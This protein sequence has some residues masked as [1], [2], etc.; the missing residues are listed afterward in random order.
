MCLIYK[1]WEET[2]SIR[3]RLGR[4]EFSRSETCRSEEQ[5]DEVWVRQEG[6]LEEHLALCGDSTGHP[7]N[8][9]ERT[10]V[11]A[12]GKLIRTSGNEVL[13]NYSHTLSPGP[14]SRRK[15][16]VIYSSEHQKQHGDCAWWGRPCLKKFKMETNKKPTEGFKSTHIL[17][18]FRCLPN[19]A[20]SPSSAAS[21][22]CLYKA[23]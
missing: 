4:R 1:S 17:A 16:P 15:G 7:I 9:T 23:P 11:R 5:N 12:G 8:E 2:V 18:R 13:P 6:N 21:L 20:W 22:A 3:W 10:Q 19:I 14:C